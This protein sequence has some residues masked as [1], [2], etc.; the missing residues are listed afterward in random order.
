VT[1]C[2]FTDDAGGAILAGGVRREAH[3]PTDLRRIDRQIVISNN[4]VQGV[5]EDFRDQS[6]IL[7]TYVSGATILHN[8]ISDVPY[9][10]IDIGY[11]WGIQDP[12]GNPNYRVHMH[13]Y[14]SPN[15][16]VYE[17]PTTHRD[18]VVASN[19][20]HGAKRFFHDGGAIYNLSAS[21]GTL[22]TENYIYDNSGMI[23]IYLDE[24]SRYINVRRNVVQDPTGEWLNINTVH[25]ALPLRI[26]IDNTASDNWHDSSKA[27][28]LWTNYENDLILDDHLVTDGHWP[29][30]AESIMRSAGIEELPKSRR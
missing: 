7:S 15:N 30:E 24:G 29:A 21:P 8:E 18:T 13:G 12:G 17:T 25:N 28:G 27:G 20:I 6:A 2:V 10:A 11:G 26:S 16:P 9:D 14:D 23:G 4:R 3:H 5:S 22:I 1:R 19:R